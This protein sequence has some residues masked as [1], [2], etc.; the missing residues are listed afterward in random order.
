MGKLKTEYVDL[1]LIHWP[2]GLASQFS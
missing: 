2:G 1:T